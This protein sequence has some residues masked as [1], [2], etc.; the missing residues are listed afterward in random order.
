MLMIVAFPLMAIA[1]DTDYSE[2]D[3]FIWSPDQ[4]DSSYNDGYS[5]LFTYTTLEWSNSGAEEVND[6]LS[7]FWDYYTME[8]NNIEDEHIG[9]IGGTTELP[10]G[11]WDPE[12]D[13]GNGLSEELEYYWANTDLEGNVNYDFD[14][15][16][17]K[18]ESSGSGDF[19][20]IAQMGPLHQGWDYDL[21]DR[22]SYNYDSIVYNPTKNWLTKFISKLR[23]SKAHASEKSRVE[24]YKIN[25]DIVF[26]VINNNGE[27]DVFPIKV[28]DVDKYTKSQLKAAKKL[29][30]EK[31]DNINCTITFN[32][33]LD[34]NAMS[35]FGFEN[36]YFEFIGQK[37]NEKI[38]GFIMNNEK[39]LQLLK[40]YKEKIDV[41]G[42]VAYTGK[43]DYLKLQK[44][45]ESDK[46][47]I[48][49]VTET[50]IKE[51]LKQKYPNVKLDIHV[52]H[53]YNK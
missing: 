42:I 5:Y 51:K 20:L 27:I 38:N 12:D 50:L 35:E 37:G 16:W 21:L 39:G 34:I 7:N 10:D 6:R 48:A 26:N 45:I 2:G 40:T 15:T 29:I 3:S 47:A 32:K 46:L 41:E 53:L 52:P 23:L 24:Q 44:L 33:P 13:D 11:S 31:N 1:R 22:F 4:Y 9:S 14:T 43:I 36:G 8:L 19:D 30:D 17:G 18:V 49:D 25:Y 28:T